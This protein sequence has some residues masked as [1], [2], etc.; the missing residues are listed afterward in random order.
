MTDFFKGFY[1]RY[2]HKAIKLDSF[3]FFICALGMFFAFSA[4]L[5]GALYIGQFSYHWFANKIVGFSLAQNYAISRMIGILGSVVTV[6]CYLN[7]IIA[8]FHY[9]KIYNSVVNWFKSTTEYSTK[10]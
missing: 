5:A 10:R 8:L 4:I 9:K 7:I 3:L 2:I 1:V 6:M